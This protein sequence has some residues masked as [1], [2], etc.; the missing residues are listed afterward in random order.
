MFDK[1]NKPPS[2]SGNAV[3]SSV[4]PLLQRRANARDVSFSNYIQYGG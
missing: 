3:V 2:R 1:V 4:S